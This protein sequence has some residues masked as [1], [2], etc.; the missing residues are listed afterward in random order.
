MTIALLLLGLFIGLLIFRLPV[1]ISLLVPSIVYI[2]LNP[3]V[4]FAVLQQ[5]IVS[6]VDSFVLLAVPMFILM[7]TLAN[8]SGVAERMFDAARAVLGNVRGSLGYVNV[9]VSLG[10]SWMNGSALADVAAT[11]RIQVPMMV[12]HGYDK[13]FSIGLTGVAALIGP[14]MPPSIPAVIFAMTA[15]VSIGGVFL[16]GIGPA[17]LITAVLLASVWLKTRKSDHLRGETME[18]REIW[19]LLLRAVPALF[20]PVILL[21]G[22]LGG[23][24]TPTEAA[25]VAVAYVLFLGLVYR[26]FTFRNLAEVLRSAAHSTASVMFIIGAAALFGWIL[27]VEGAQQVVTAALGSFVSETW[28]FLIVLNLMLLLIG[29]VMET[30]ALIL[31]LVPVLFPIA[32]DFGVDP[33]HFGVIVV[34]NLMVGL[35]TP[36]LG[37]LLFML[38]SVTSA[39]MKDVVLGVAQFA[40]PLLVCMVLITFV[41]AVSL[42]IPAWFGG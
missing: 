37:L 33:L 12:K 2:A 41:P 29:T 1:G 13:R 3:T 28:Q 31:I 17:L 23:Y 36:P 25:G 27:T 21:G 10:F 39:S 38:K 18:R 19:R 35:L 9:F 30:A 24:F 32:M 26:S 11:G 15:G 4:S 34:F 5:Q 40:V 22:I 14:V 7:G 16:A 8:A 42:S 6:G 20:T